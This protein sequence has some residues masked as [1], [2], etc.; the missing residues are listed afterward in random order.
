MNIC[1]GA[2]FPYDSRQLQ[3]SQILEVNPV[4]RELVYFGMRYVV[5]EQK[6]QD[7]SKFKMPATFR[8]RSAWYVQMWWIVQKL[9]FNSSPQVM[10]GWRNFLLRCFGAEIG[11]GV[12]VRPSASIVY[13]WKLKIGNYSWI[14]DDVNLYTL[15][16]IVIGAHSVVSQ[17]CYLCAGSHKIESLS[18][19]IT[20]DPIV[21][22]DE[23]WIASDVFVCP[24]VRIGRG[25]VVGAR[26]TVTR[27]LP[28][29]SIA[30]GTPARVVGARPLSSAE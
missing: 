30:L 18:F 24:G 4:G 27:N 28:S 17:K 25:T 12:L 16:E 19:E 6:Y 7:L 2:T 5:M 22:E 15:G 21:I 23:C 11:K 20:S 29:G 26:S 14:G 9:L 10:Y 1:L 3:E 8:G 13:P